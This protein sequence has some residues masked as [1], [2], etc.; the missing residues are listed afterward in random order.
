MNWQ[1]FVSE[2]KTPRCSEFSSKGID[3][4]KINQLV[5]RK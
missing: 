1:K 2:N 3:V 4:R 5:V